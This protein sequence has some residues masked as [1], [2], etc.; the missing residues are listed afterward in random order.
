M[1][2]KFFKNWYPNSTEQFTGF[3]VSNHIWC[4]QKLIGPYITSTVE[5]MSLFL[6]SYSNSGQ[7]SLYNSFFCRLYLWQNWI[8]TATEAKQ[9]GWNSSF[10]ILLTFWY[11][12]FLQVNL[13]CN[14]R[15]E[16]SIKQSPPLPVSSCLQSRT[17]MKWPTLIFAAQICMKCTWRTGSLKNKHTN[18]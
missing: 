2:N 9:D 8:P 18:T 17:S 4:K 5:L 7:S 12:S 10:W 11:N 16:N 3:T 13:T 6:S 1:E 15:K 14:G